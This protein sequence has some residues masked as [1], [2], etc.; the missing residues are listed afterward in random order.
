LGLTGGAENFGE[1]DLNLDFDNFD[2]AVPD[3]HDDRARRESE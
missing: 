2:G 1:V 3:L